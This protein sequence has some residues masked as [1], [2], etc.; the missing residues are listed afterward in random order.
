MPNPINTV[1]VDFRLDAWR[2]APY[3]TFVPALL[4]GPG[5]QTVC[6]PSLIEDEVAP[7]D[8]TGLKRRCTWNL[9]ALGGTPITAYKIRCE[10]TTDNVLALFHVSERVD[11]GV[12]LM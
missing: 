8:P 4:T 9:A 2:D 3:H 11:I 10:G 7:D 6:P 1:Y 12:N 5:Y